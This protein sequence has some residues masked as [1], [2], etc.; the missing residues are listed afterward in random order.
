MKPV[1]FSWHLFDQIPI[2][3]IMRNIP[4]DRISEVATV[5]ADEGL[6]NLEITLN[7]PGAVELITKLSARFKGQINVGAGTVCTSLELD[8]AIS[9][10]AVFVVTPIVNEEIIQKCVLK[11]IP[12]FPGA[13]TPTEIHKAT[14]FGASMVKVFPASTLGPRYIKELLGP[15]PQF[16][17]LP[18]GGISLENMDDFLKAG[19]KGVG[20]GSHLFPIE[21]IRE[22]R[23]EDLRKIFANARDVFSD[24]EGL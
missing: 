22:K 14:T 8:M 13:Y 9:A 16:K 6:T 7:S 10:G 15:F 19:A 24:K 3:G 23:W 12:V 18:T 2:I 20:I 4:I 17:L 11:G 21:I 1:S 5:F